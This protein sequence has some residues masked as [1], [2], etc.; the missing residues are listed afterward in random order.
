MR[1]CA[2]EK[3]LKGKFFMKKSLLSLLSLL[4][5]LIMI[6]GVFASCTNGSG[7]TETDESESQ[8]P[9]G[10]ES[11]ST[12]DG[13][14]EDE[15]DPVAPSEH[16]ALIQAANGL[17]NGVQAYFPD[18]KRTHYSLKN[19]EMIMNY[20]RSNQFDQLVES[21]KTL[22]GATYI[23]NT[24]DV[25]VRMA[26][27]DSYDTYY[28]SQS[29]KSAEANL[30]RFGYYYYQGLFEFQNFVPK[31]FEVINTTEINIKS[32]Y[33]EGY[34][35]RRTR[36][37]ENIAYTITPGATDPRILFENDF[38]YVAAEND[39]LVIRAKALG[40]TNGVQLFVKTDT[41]NYSEA[42]CTSFSVENDG[43]YH[44]YYIF[45]S[46]I[47]GYD[48]NLKGIRFDPNGTEG[49]GI[50]I[51]SMTL[52]KANVG[53]VPSSLSINRHFHV[54]SDKMH[55]AIQ[56]AVTER[57]EGIVEVGMLTEIPADTVSK[58]IIVT[59]D[60]KNYDSLNA[61]FAW[62]DVVAVGFDVTAAGIFG[63]ILP[64][65]E[66]AGKIK[67]ELKDDVYVIE[68]TRTPEVDGVSGV[69]IPSIDTEKKDKNGNYVHADGV[70]NNGNDFYIGQRIYTDEN[71]DF[72][73]FLMETDFERNP[74]ISQR[75]SVNAESSDGASF[76]GYDAMRG[77]YVLNIGMP[78]GGFYTP[79]KSPSKDYKVNF[80][81][82]ADKDRGIY[83]MTAGTSG[84]LE[85][86]TLMDEDMMLLPVPIEVIKNFSEA[87]GERNLYNISDPSFSEAIFY[88]P[89]EQN[90]KQEYTLI[91]IYQNWGNYPLKQ[92][93]QIPFHCPYY[94][95]STGVTETNC[96]LPWFGTANV[97]KSNGGTLPDFRSMSAPFWFSQPQHNSCGS[98][99]WLAYTDTDGGTYYVESQRNDITSYGPTYAEVV[100][101]NLSDDGKIK[102]TYT[103][104]EMP[105]LDE[106]RTYYT[107]E[108]EFLEDLTIDSFKDNFQFYNVT[109]NNGKGTYKK[110]GYLDVNNESQVVDANQD[111]EVVPEYVLG[112]NCP[113]FSFFMMPD[114]NRESTSAE[115]YANVALLIYTS[116][117]IIGGE[118]KEYNFLIKN[119]KG[120][121]TLTLNEAG[122]I[123]FKAGDKITI[124][125]ILLPWG[126]QE[127]E[128]DPANRLAANMPLPHVSSATH[129]QENYHGYTYSSVLPDGTLYMDKN[130]RDV[131]ENTLLN[132]LT[133]SSETDEI[134][135]S[136]FLPKVKSKDG[137]T[138]EFTLSGGQ[139]NVTVR[140]YGFDMLTA[141][142]V[143]E[144]VD[145]EWVEYTLSSHKTPDKNGYYHYYDGYQVNYDEDGTYSYS[146]VTTMYD[147][148]PRKFRIAADTEFAGWPRE[149]E[150]PENENL[151]TGYTD[152]EELQQLLDES[153]MF[154]TP[155]INQDEDGTNYISVYVKV[156]NAAY[157]H[158]SYATVY[159]SGSETDISGKYL[160]IKYRVPNSN[161]ES[162]G[163]FQ[164]WS[165]TQTSSAVEA[166]SFTYSP[167]AD[168]EWHVVVFD[169][170]KSSLKSFTANDS[171]DYCARFVR[172][173]IFNKQ[174]FDEETH[175]DIAYIGMDPDIMKICELELENFK[176]ITI[177]ENGKEGEIDTTTGQTY[178]KSYID[179][180][181]GYTES[182]LPFGSIIDSINGTAVTLNNY[183]TKN[184]IQVYHGTSVNKDMQITLAGWACVDGGINKYVWSVDGKTWI[185]FPDQEKLGNA[186]DAMIDNVIGAKVTI[187]DREASK[188]NG[189]FKTGTCPLIADLSPYAG[190]TVDITVAAVPESDTDT[191]VLL[192]YLS[193]INCKYESIFADESAYREAQVLFGTN[194]DTVNGIASNKASSTPT[195]F[196]TYTDVT[197][198]D[199]NTILLKGW[200]AVDGGV[201]KY[202]WT[203][204]G[205]KTWND[206]GGKCYSV[207]SNE[208]PSKDI[209]LVGQKR[210][211]GTFGNVEATQKNAGFQGDG[212]IIDL[213]AYA[214]TDEPLDIY[215]CAVTESNQGNVVILYL[216]KGVTLPANAN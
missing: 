152:H 175:I 97:G 173:D 29:T 177:V 154:G 59:D 179:P 96:I 143:Q 88:L 174:F 128:D 196:H 40:N 162:V 123:N 124:N 38:D 130:V 12:P 70:T 108:Y 47:S 65:D 36:D 129:I 214:G 57:T 95:L 107:M 64:K 104:M 89:L 181:S 42:S 112:D 19:T 77:I 146:F 163:H 101:E 194:I 76:A 83:I 61:G 203:A 147:G 168:G 110:L 176:S 86:A 20:A 91:N 138:A 157:N 85:C 21:I 136:P 206:C 50:A 158:E 1:V 73:E 33:K 180:A 44:T 68:Q 102:V 125:A 119:R 18:A 191:L 34:E 210:S 127:L 3:T 94:H 60:G 41:T 170:S 9:G 32:Q 134:I 197:A 189:N 202:V 186:T 131:R 159:S 98:H 23:Q 56:F 198:K 195:G 208:D 139:N 109:D 39:T 92:L 27:G 55:H 11:S 149:Q 15:K 172:L 28:A 2:R 215:F 30:Y 201:T 137:K 53:E 145:G 31:N 187:S 192:Y 35:V 24:M 5:A 193:G 140:I 190:Q 93:S 153:A 113:Y 51:E 121:V 169:L 46:S 105:Q 87:T 166:G 58:L 54:Y 167:V 79:Y 165:S 118:E 122:T 84:I 103:H 212:L 135:E 4:L 10:E 25:F 161:T 26:N 43:E 126:S 148:A 160:V 204:D 100:W 141:P 72:S 183:T 14:D 81:I 52:G 207:A 6:A 114:W 66:I 216:F 200:A 184:G 117:F 22:D 211:G 48:G 16:L 171:G 63:F 209:V 78:S 164:I 156:D 45:L 155:V 132:P 49:G 178:V 17:A 74:L 69:I 99:T 106:N 133:V 144:Y 115:G 213:S 75:V 205:G 182:T 111:A 80:N 90:K 120:N 151:L 116:D 8:N 188:K 67:V 142:K 82:R 185:D 62:E 71:H 150:P 13:G 7:N 199:D 37:G